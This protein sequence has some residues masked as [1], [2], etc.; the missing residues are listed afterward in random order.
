[1]ANSLKDAIE[2]SNRLRQKQLDMEEARLQWEAER[3]REE[4]ERREQEEERERARQNYLAALPTCKY[5]GE[6]IDYSASGCSAIFEYCCK[7]CAI[8]DLGK[9]HFADYEDFGYYRLAKKLDDLTARKDS[10]RLEIRLLA[11]GVGSF[12]R[13]QC[14]RIAQAYDMETAVLSRNRDKAEECLR[15]WLGGACDPELLTNTAQS[16]HTIF[17]NVLP[18]LI[19][20]YLAKCNGLIDDFLTVEQQEIIWKYLRRNYAFSKFARLL[21]LN[22]FLRHSDAQKKRDMTK[23]IMFP[24]ARS[25]D[26]AI[27]LALAGSYY[28]YRDNLQDAAFNNKFLDYFG[29]F[30]PEDLNGFAQ[31]VPDGPLKEI[32]CLLGKKAKY[33]NEMPTRFGA[34][35]VMS[36]VGLFIAQSWGPLLVIPAAIF[37]Y[38]IVIFFY[39]QKIRNILGEKVKWT[40]SKQVTANTYLIPSILATI[41]C[42][43]L[44]IVSLFFAVKANSCEGRQDIVGAQEAAGKAK[45]CF[46]FALGCGIIIIILGVLLVALSQAANQA[47]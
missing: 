22:L 1:M 46:W 14:L 30:S 38:P 45:L 9:E 40:A 6:S 20:S 33:E 29:G 8:A 31:K 19:D 21:W 5:C 18:D 24:K 35:V 2:E 13:E 37:A 36:V 28:I 7:K 27:L 3:A 34:I 15:F 10:D 47:D 17:R 11:N 39:N 23:N 26:G 43:P 44:G 12:S 4:E 42:L 41:F 25:I 16:F 32:L